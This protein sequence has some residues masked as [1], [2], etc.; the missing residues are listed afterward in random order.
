MAEAVG[1]YLR[2]FPE[3][4]AA[5]VP[6]VPPGWISVADQMPEKGIPVL[7]INEI[8]KYPIRAC[9]IAKFSQEAG[10]DFEG[11]MD[12]SEA[13]DEHYWPEG[14]YDWNLHE[15]THWFAPGITHWM[16]LPPAPGA[17]SPPP[18]SLTREQEIGTTAQGG[19]SNG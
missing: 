7:A 8:S 14:W 17:A 2:M 12:Y 15:G 1:E 19:P 3:K 9:W 10:C 18:A 4:F 16:P 5:P 6:A 13:N 11:D